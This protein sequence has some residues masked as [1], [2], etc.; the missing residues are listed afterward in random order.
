MQYLKFT[1]IIWCLS[2]SNIFSQT[3]QSINAAWHK[4]DTLVYQLNQYV[5]EQLENSRADTLERVEKQLQMVVVDSSKFGYLIEW[6]FKTDT[7]S[8]PVKDPFVK[9]KIKLQFKTS[10]LGVMQEV[11]NWETI[12]KQIFDEIELIIDNQLLDSE[13]LYWG[14]Q[15]LESAYYFSTYEGITSLFIK[16][17][18]LMHPHY[19]TVY[20]LGEPINFDNDIKV[21]YGEGNI[22]AKGKMLCSVNEDGMIQIRS[23]TKTEEAA[24]KSYYI[25]ILETVNGKLPRKKRK[26]IAKSE[27]FITEVSNY[28]YHAETFHLI[29]GNFKRTQLL[30]DVYTTE[31]VE[32]NLK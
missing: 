29:K 14:S 13:V 15:P 25:N 21:T 22:P 32:I 20:N 5:I 31:V 2:F 17:I 28:I 1:I 11:I 7:I 4:N 27:L 6:N 18:Q 3:K 16:D 23:D 26:E 19:G 24:I 10:L 30:D 12:R 8:G 9:Q